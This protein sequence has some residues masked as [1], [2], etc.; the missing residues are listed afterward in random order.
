MGHLKVP[1][2]RNSYINHLHQPFWNFQGRLITCCFLFLREGFL[3]KFFPFQTSPPKRVPSRNPTHPLVSP[4]E[5][6]GNLP[7]KA[8]KGSESRLGA[9]VKVCTR[10]FK[11]PFL[12][13]LSDPFK[14]LSDLQLGDTKVTLNRL[15]GSRLL[16][17]SL[18]FGDWQV[19]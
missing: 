11:V 5:K 2:L 18:S 15:V 6:I 4:P 19:P 17:G 12:G 9:L 1:L 10:W 8:R 13:W 7:K 16:V 14:G 3:F